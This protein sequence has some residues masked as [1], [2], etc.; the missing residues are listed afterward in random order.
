M[1]HWIYKETIMIIIME[2]KSTEAQAQK[3]IELL[4]SSGFDIRYKKG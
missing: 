2:P 3:V 1:I 4:K